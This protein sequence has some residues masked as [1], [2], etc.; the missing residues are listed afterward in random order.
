[1]RSHLEETLHKALG[2]FAF[3]AVFL[4]HSSEVNI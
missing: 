2:A 3:N 4:V 1:M